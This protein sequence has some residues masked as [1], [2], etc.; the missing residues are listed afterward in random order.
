M[1]DPDLAGRVC[2]V[3]GASRGIG[4]VTA[5]RLAEMGA[6]VALVGRDPVA[7]SQALAEVR[8]ASGRSNATLHLTDFASLTAVRRLAA[9]LLAAHPRIHVLVNNAGLW[10]NSRQESED[11]F[12]KT[13]AVNH[14]APFLLTNLL[15]ERMKESAPARIVNVASTAHHAARGVGFDDLMLEKRYVGNAAYSRSKLANVLFTRELARRIAGSGVTATCC[16]PGSVATDLGRDPGLSKLLYTLGRVVMV[17]PEK[18][19][20]TQVWLAS[21]PDVEGESGGYYSRKHRGRPSKAAQDDAAAGR[22]W[23]VS[24]RLVGLT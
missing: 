3:T 14:L 13:L 19:A 24:A 15:L 17:G 9:D 16:H 23:D 10:L 12:E 21:D 8:E 2:V 5:R 4:T 1:T 6:T 11:G 18:G 22:L 7:S 20:R